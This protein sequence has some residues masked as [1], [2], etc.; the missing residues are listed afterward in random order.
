MTTAL[1]KAS[2]EVPSGAPTHASVREARFRLLI[3][4][5]QGARQSISSF[6]YEILGCWNTSTVVRRPWKLP[7]VVVRRSALHPECCATVH[8]TCP[9]SFD[10]DAANAETAL[11]AAGQITASLTSAMSKHTNHSANNGPMNR[12]SLN[13]THRPV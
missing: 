12:V 4:S 5:T 6:R 8:P 2:S 1:S 7:L 11:F 13:T 10:S 9:T 3:S